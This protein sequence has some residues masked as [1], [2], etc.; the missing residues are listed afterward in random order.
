MLWT[1]L[2]IA[3]RNL[4]KNRPYVLINI[5]G[6]AIGIACCLLIFLIIRFETSFDNF[7]P[8]K[9]RIYRIVSATPT[10]KRDQLNKPTKS[11]TPC[12]ETTSKLPSAA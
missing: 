5:G 12:S 2:K 7:H 8:D 10:P 6:L 1:Y 4:A 11:P 3:A 9:D